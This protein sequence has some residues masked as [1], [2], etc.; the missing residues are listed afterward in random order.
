MCKL[1]QE[2]LRDGFECFESLNSFE[3]MLG[4]ELWKGD[5]SLTLDLVKDYI[6]GS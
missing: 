2:L 1:I 5:L 3:K 4:S 6:V